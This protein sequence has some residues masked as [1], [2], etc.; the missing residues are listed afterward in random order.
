MSVLAWQFQSSFLHP[1]GPFRFVLSSARSKE[2]I[3]LLDL[4]QTQRQD[5]VVSHSATI[6]A[7]EK[8]G[9]W[10]LALWLFTT[11]EMKPDLQCCNSLIWAI[12][13]ATEWKKTLQLFQQLGDVQANAI[14]LSACI[15]A[16]E[17]SDQWWE[18]LLLLDMLN[19]EMG[20]DLSL[21]Q[22]HAKM[23]G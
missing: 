18:L 1:F 14:T 21:R 9:L 10:K 19:D 3:A 12:S 5:D 13:K 22:A 2:A 20:K 23:P 8:A 11:M 16:C 4:L 6:S 15:G 17:M 7:C